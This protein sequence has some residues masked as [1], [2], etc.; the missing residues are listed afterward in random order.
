M[1]VSSDLGASDLGPDGPDAEPLADLGPADADLIEGECTPGAARCLREGDPVLEICQEREGV[2]RWALS[3]CPDGEICQGGQCVS[4]PMHCALGDRTCLTADTP[5]VCEPGVGFVPDDACEAGTVCA[6][7]G[8]CLSQQCAQAEARS[9]YLGCDYLVLDLPNLS[10]HPLGGTTPDAPT[11][12]VI[13]NPDTT[14]PTRIT[15]EGFNGD[16]APLVAETTVAVPLQAPFATPQDLETQV[17]DADGLVVASAFDRAVDLEIPPGGLATLH[18]PPPGAP[19]QTSYIRANARRLIAD[20]P[21]AV[22]QFNPYCC[23]YSF[24]NDASLLLPT[25]ALGT[26]YIYVGVP[27]WPTP[28]EEPDPGDPIPPGGDP[29]GIPA[30]LVVAATAPGTQVQVDLPPGVEI[31]DIDGPIERQGQQITATLQTNQVLTLQSGQPQLIRGEA[32]GPDLSGARI[33]A[34][35]P[36]SVFSSH[37]CAFY[38]QDLAACDHLEEQILPVSTWGQ[39]YALVPTA[40]RSD[41]ERTDEAIY[42]KLAAQGDNTEIT[43]S[44]PFAD[45]APRRPGFIGV[46]Y[47]G[48]FLRDERTLALN[49]GQICEFGTA[50]PAL[51]TSDQPIMVMGI[52]SGQVSTGNNVPDGAS[53][54]DPAIFILPPS[55]QYRM[56]YAFLTPDTYAVDYVTLISEPDTRVELDGVAIDLGVGEAIPGSTQVFRHLQISDGPHRLSG[57]GAFGILV[58][59]FDDYVSYAFTGGLNLE[60]R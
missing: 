34:S 15:L 14:R 12:V 38:P 19:P 4:D 27:T 43:L 17:R 10:Q 35:R 22:Y 7:N 54:G 41:V 3:P 46:P 60:K 52:I 39:E 16:P 36:V 53:A 9:S 8:R 1:T 40:P 20:L 13:T 50:R 56:A 21:V 30:A 5:G 26:D 25:S 2:G 57:N 37:Q 59:A 29:S 45:L 28:E 6:G 51:A 44:V 55:R 23:N 32:V 11:S 18:L 48:D 31:A 33:T 47:C 58:Y 42:W 49:D 24:S